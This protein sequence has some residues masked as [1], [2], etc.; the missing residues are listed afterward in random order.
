MPD[1]NM[2][3]V[4]P[5]DV[6]KN[7]MLP[8]AA[9]APKPRP[10]S[11]RLARIAL[12]HAMGR[13]TL[14]EI[15]EQEGYSSIFADTLRDDSHYMRLYKSQLV[16]LEKDGYNFR[17]KAAKLADDTLTNLAEIANDTDQPG[18]ARISAINTL[19]E[20]GGLRV[21]TDNAAMPTI[22]VNIDL[23]GT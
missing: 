7:N 9:F 6:N 21:K 20:L 4:E 11:D 18:S 23:S 14:E 1:V 3:D 12:A 22:N 8:M 10:P 2:I 13:D 17:I 5:Q 19:A 16:Q 15:L